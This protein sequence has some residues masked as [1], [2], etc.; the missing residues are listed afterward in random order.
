[1]GYKKTNSLKNLILILLSCALVLSFSAC[2]GEEEISQPESSVS[3]EASQSLVLELEEAKQLIEQDRLITD[4]F[5]NNALCS[6]NIAEYRPVVAADRY[7]D[8]AKLQALLEDTYTAEGGAIQAMLSYPNKDL[9]AVKSIDGRTNV[10]NHAGSSFNGFVDNQSVSVA[11]TAVE[12]EKIITATAKDGGKIEFTALYSDGK[13]LLEKGI[14]LLNSPKE[15]EAAEKF[16]NSSLGSFADFSGEILVIELFILDN[17]SRFVTADK[18]VFHEK[19]ENSFNSILKH[20]EEYGV[21]ANITYER[22]DYEHYG[23]IG[24]NPLDFDIA[25]AETSFGTLQS[26][27][28]AS[29]D[30]SPYDNYIVAV[31]LN[32]EAETGYA[33]YDG[34]SHTE[35]HLGERILLGKN[36]LETDICTSL[37]SVLG[38]YGYDEGRCGEFIE[39]L[40]KK[41]FPN[42]IMVSENSALSEISPVTA[43][44][45]G[46]TD[47]LIPLYRVFNYK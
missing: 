28:D 9:P 19:I 25:F 39:A 8:Y 45:C 2:G 14:F 41:Y 4:I 44:A 47:E 23:I 6:K 20:A 40:Y 29:Y 17:E 3:E 35:I 12:T 30:L 11:D 43:Y 36:A 31:C 24:Q 10:L 22:I 16:P 38:A 21:D 42:D 18:D 32:K 26:F 34:T 33:L 13:W 37:L 5:V 15:I 46:M 7:S 1:M 27:A